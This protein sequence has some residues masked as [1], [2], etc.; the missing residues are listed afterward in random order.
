M[1]KH[2]LVINREV[3]DA[4]AGNRAVVA[5]EST[6]ISHGMPYPQN[7]E[8]AKLL[9]QT[10]RDNGGIPA[11]IAVLNGKIHVG[12]SED[13]LEFLATDKNIAKASRRD[14]PALLAGG[15]HAATTV[16][17]TMIC[18]ALSGVRFF[19]TGGIGG[20][21][22][23]AAETMDISADLREFAETPV[24]VVSAGAKAI[25]DIPLTMEYLETMGVPVI[26]Y[27]TDEMPAFYYTKSGVKIPVRVDSAAEAAAIFKTS[28][29]MGY[30]S[31]VL[32]GNP[33][34]ESDALDRNQIEACI[35]QALSDAQSRGV[36][37]QQVTP[38][39]LGRL[40]EITGGESLKTNI[41]LVRNNVVVCTKIAVEFF[42]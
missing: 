19:A 29:A 12:L 3:R 40:N 23:G 37:G 38:F 10:V 22:R 5:L 18:A 8:T 2:N 39:L 17:A 31:G 30:R 11:T 20:V 26:G 1:L 41:A 34:P 9:E 15:R 4:I 25:L 16:A 7:I 14:L 32:V 6:I 35:A 33:I 36:N 24:L 27:C 13:E 28:L 42:K 21:H